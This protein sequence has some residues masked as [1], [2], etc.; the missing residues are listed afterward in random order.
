MTHSDQ[1]IVNYS[2]DWVPGSYLHVYNRACYRNRLFTNDQ[3]RHRF[4]KNLGRYIAP[5]ID[6]HAFNLI[7]DHFHLTCWLKSV[8]AITIILRARK[9]LTKTE[10]SFLDG[11]VPY[12][13][14]I[15]TYWQ[16]CMAGYAVYLNQRTPRKGHLFGQNIR[17][18]LF[19]DNEFH[20]EPQ[21]YVLLNHKKHNW[22]GE[23]WTSL[24][25]KQRPSWVKH[26]E[27]VHAFGGDAEFQEYLRWY[28]AARGKAFHALDEEKYFRIGKKDFG[29]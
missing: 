24:D 6:V 20:R 12:P 18:V 19:R 11:R 23:P 27:M 22:P 1:Y 10:R 2:E 16:R 13:D 7:P 4:L 17:R 29:A 5:F 14:L 9:G 25:P 21:A 8:E 26:D 15:K 28:L 3:Q